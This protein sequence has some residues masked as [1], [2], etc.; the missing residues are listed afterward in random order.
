MD[1]D[2]SQKIFVRVARSGKESEAVGSSHLCKE[3]D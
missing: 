3:V 1:R 2:N